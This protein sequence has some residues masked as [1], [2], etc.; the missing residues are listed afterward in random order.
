[1]YCNSAPTHSLSFFLATPNPEDMSQSQVLLAAA[2]RWC[3]KPRQADAEA[4]NKLGLRQKLF[5]PAFQAR[6][7]TTP[8]NLGRCNFFEAATSLRPGRQ[9]HRILKQCVRIGRRS[10]HKDLATSAEAWGLTPRRWRAEALLSGIPAKRK[11]RPSKAHGNSQKSIG[12][13]VHKWTATGRFVT[14]PQPVATERGLRSTPARNAEA[15][16]ST[17]GAEAPERTNNARRY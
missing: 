2:G 9:V 12:D 5:V 4:S 7:E 8:N 11:Q 3:G 17:K 16:E 1:M 6:R 14:N 10:T 15:S 13:R